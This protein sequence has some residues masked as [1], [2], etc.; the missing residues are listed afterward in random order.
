M[1]RILSFLLGSIALKISLTVAALTAMTGTAV[2]IGLMVFNT[3]SASFNALLAEQLPDLRDSVT[4]IQHSAGIRDSLSDMLLARSSSDV[5]EAQARFQ[6]EKN[7]LAKGMN[8]LP[9]AT[10][11]EMIPALTDLEQ[12]VDEMQSAIK[13]GFAQQAALETTIAGFRNLSAWARELLVQLTED[14]VYDMG[15]AGDQTIEVVASTLGN[16][17]DYDFAA[18]T[19][20]L[21]ARG[22]VNL[23]SGLA[24][25]LSETEDSALS[26]SLR[27]IAEASLGELDTILADLEERD[28]IPD[29]LPA[30]TEIRGVVA[31]AARQGFRA[32]A[33]YRERLMEL[34]EES[35]LALTY[36]IDD[37]TAT[38]MIGAEDTATFNQDAI[39]RLLENEVQSIRDAANLEI[40]VETVVATAFLGATVRSLDAIGTAQA[41][42]DDAASHLR[43]LSENVYLT[44]DLEV[45]VGQLLAFTAAE[46]GIVATRAEVLTAEA[47][48]E[49]TSHAAH[50]RLRLIG[51]LAASHGGVALTGAVE[52]GDAILAESERA[53]RRLELVAMGSVAIL[54]AAPFL[55]WLLILRPMSRLERL[56]VRLSKGDLAPITGF[57]FTGGE[58]GR[59]ATALGVFREGLIERGRMQEHERLAEEE[60]QKRAE[61][62]HALVT[63]LAE[64]LQRLSSGDLTES[65]D[66]PFP[67]DYEQLRHD[68][69]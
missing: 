35:N 67:A 65:L 8:G 16:L 29:H 69:N 61:E 10:V 24:I 6:E 46:D 47:R 45:I 66:A 32:R 41:Q 15:L 55:T 50:E 34:R 27:D 18:T 26:D 63:R 53:E 28:A 62:Q 44:D 21:R 60:R 1:R 17:V 19:L 37:L 9:D 54:I 40:A 36:A 20:V 52:A 23:L 7:F 38:L 14:A 43:E 51:D 59:M 33:G 56:T 2:V 64:A 5:E 4:V 13:E 25:A 31:E 39:T 12:R 42:L 30:L 58:I 11:A 48:A 57:R 49:Q 3:L 68:F 22:E